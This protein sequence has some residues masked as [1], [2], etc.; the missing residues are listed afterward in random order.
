MMKRLLRQE[1]INLIRWLIRDAPE[2]AKIKNELATVFVEEMEDG[3]M[4]SLRV[5]S[6]KERFYS[7]DIGQAEMLDE[8]GIP[9]II[10]VN[11]DTDGNF[12]EL[13]IWKVDFSPLKK[14]PDIPEGYV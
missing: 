14:I 3:G 13:D 8:D 5:V 1:E 2:G 4:G 6:D 12:F 10:S 7:R 11:I 9:L